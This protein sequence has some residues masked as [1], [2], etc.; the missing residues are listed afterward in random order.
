VRERRK[1]LSGIIFVILLFTFTTI[2]TINVGTVSGED[3]PVISVEPPTS[4]AEVG[5]SFT[6]DINITDVSDL[7]FWEFFMNFSS[8]ILNVYSVVEGP[9]LSDV[10]S[11]S[12]NTLPPTIDNTAGTV[13]ASNLLWDFPA[14]GASGNG[15]LCTITF[16]PKDV[17]STTLHF[18]YTT[19]A[20]WNGTAYEAIEHT[21][22]DGS[23]TAEPGHDAAVVSITAPAEV[24][25]NSS[26]PID[27]TVKN[28]GFFTE[29]VNV[30]I[31][32]DGTFVDS[33]NITNLAAG[34]QNTTTLTWDTTGLPK[35]DYTLNAT[36][37]ISGDNDPTDNSKTT[38]IGIVEHDAAIIDLEV[39][40]P[41]H[42]G[43]T[44]PINVTAKNQG[45]Y[46]ETLNVTI[47]H[48]GTLIGFNDTVVL[49]PQTST[50][51][52]FS[53]N[54][55]FTN[56][57]SV[58]SDGF[59]DQ[60]E[61]DK[62]DDNGATVWTYASDQKH[63]GVNSSKSTSTTDGDLTSDDIDLSDSVANGTFTCW[64]MKDDTETDEFLLYF[65]NGTTYNLIV[66][67]DAIA[68]GV[69][70]T[71]LSYSTNITSE[72][73]VSDF[74][75]R[76]TT[77]ALA[78]TENVWV[79]DVSVNETTYALGTYTINGT[80]TIPV[81]DDPTDNS[82]TKEVTLELY[83]DVNVIDLEFS[84]PAH[85]GDTVPIN[86]TVKNEGDYTEV[87]N[88]TIRY[89]GAHNSSII[90][91]EIMELTQGQSKTANF[92]WSTTGVMP[93]IYQIK[94]EAT[95]LVS[96]T[97]PTGI[98]DDLG[99]NL[100]T[101]GLILRAHDVKVTS[102]AAPSHG[103]ANS[104]VSIDVT[105]KNEGYGFREA[106]NVTLEYDSVLIGFNDTIDLPMG[107]SITVSFTWY[108]TSVTPGNYNLTANATVLVS[109]TNPTGIDDD[110]TDNTLDDV[111]VFITIAGDVDGNGTVDNSDLFELSQAY[112]SKPGDSNWN[113]Y[114][115]FNGDDKVDILDMAN[116]GK[117]HGKTV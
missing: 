2:G 66:D 7:F 80:V 47:S 81:D 73:W 57:A 3:L 112:G 75:V 95:V 50:I 11:T 63:S 56:T 71:W 13:L 109:A 28:E 14:E 40:S 85:L 55:N 82:M 114:C 54:T 113:P 32:R 72:Y 58:F 30:T 96:A 51:V 4:T 16:Q 99:D 102:I 17:G 15:T 86:V 105:V 6:V 67:L 70:D 92:T 10:D 93:G 49:N 117:N 101:D 84:S 27:V 77:V 48:D 38:T 37:T 88:V 79:D 44:V 22:E 100:V 97:N 26:V 69:D 106:V 43:D 53:W 33:K 19:L 46:T 91:Y 115:D 87:A 76:F 65:W 12:W 45:S 90:D 110:P 39:S 35:G 20:T 52:P 59:E 1:R 74:R 21:A 103:Y 42:F 108:T 116:L 107:S 23:V 8:T 29:N 61:F 68:I 98:D 18:N 9:F 41:V 25:S 104:S 24:A 60:P 34:T 78:T 94:A 62:W 31:R 36:A 5:E 64:F 83:H 111:T 89:V